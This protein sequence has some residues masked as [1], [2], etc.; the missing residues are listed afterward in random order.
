MPG[1]EVIVSGGLHTYQQVTGE[2]G[3]AH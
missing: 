3:V 2:I 1:V